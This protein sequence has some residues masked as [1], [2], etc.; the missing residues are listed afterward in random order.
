MHAT[1]RTPAPV[2]DLEG[3]T[4]AYVLNRRRLPTP[5]PIPRPTSPRHRQQPVARD[6]RAAV[7]PRVHRYTDSLALSDEY[8][9]AEWWLPL[10]RRAFPR[11]TSAVPVKDDGWAQRAG[12]DRV[13]TLACG[14]TYTI[15]EKIRTADWPDVLLEQWSDEA[16]RVPGWVQKPLACDFIAYAYAPSA[17]GVSADESGSSA[18]ASVAPTIPVTCQRACPCRAGC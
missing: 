6:R 4:L 16:R 1:I 10:Y 14:R 7:S 5:E 18:T 13:L 9:D 3:R 2:Y 15:D 8:R 17:R 11:L 12:I